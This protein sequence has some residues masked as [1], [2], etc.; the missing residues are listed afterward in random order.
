MLKSAIKYKKKKKFDV[1]QATIRLKRVLGIEST[2]L[3][4]LLEVL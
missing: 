4:Y 3:K 1:M 2:L